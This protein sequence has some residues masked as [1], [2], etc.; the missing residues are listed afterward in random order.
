MADPVIK[1]SL[2]SG[3]LTGNPQPTPGK[4]DAPLATD[5]AHIAADPLVREEVAVVQAAL[6]RIHDILDGSVPMITDAR[7]VFGSSTRAA[8]LKYKSERGTRRTGSALDGIV[9]RGTFSVLDNDII[10]VEGGAVPKP[11]VPKPAVRNDILIF[12]SGV[13][14]PGGTELDDT[15]PDTSGFLERKHM[16]ALADKAPHAV[17][18]AVGGALQF[19]EM[20]AGWVI[21]KK[22]ILDNLAK[23]QGKL[24]IYGYSA[25]GTNALEFTRRIEAENLVRQVFDR[26]PIE[27]TLLVTVDAADRTDAPLKVV[28]AVGGSVSANLNFFQTRASP[29]LGSGAHGGPNIGLPSTIT[30]KSPFI[31]N[32]DITSELDIVSASS[33]H[34]QVEKASLKRCQQA[35][36]FALNP[37]PVLAPQLHRFR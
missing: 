2:Q 31:Q 5:A 35:I 10:R 4:L 30:G 11:Q 13:Q 9:G 14:T 27:V 19:D 12:L 23:P 34:N 32:R 8:V 16:K 33:S 25:G 3:L 36:E 6:G 15:T 20:E 17:F 29:G 21:V 18:K 1:A 37:H 24:I 26:P 22:F 7:G 28:R